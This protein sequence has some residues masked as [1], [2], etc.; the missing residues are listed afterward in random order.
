MPTPEQILSGLDDISNQWRT[1]AIVWHAY[2]GVLVLALIVRLGASKRVLGILLALP[3]LSV[4]AL[5][6]ASG[7]PFNGSFFACLG[8]G[9]IAIALAFPVDSTRVAPF[10]EVVSGSLMFLFGWV[11]PHFVDTS[12]MVLYL[13]AAPTGFLAF[14]GLMTVAAILVN[15][16]KPVRESVD[17]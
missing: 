10:W 16:K 3:L 13:Y 7:N 4:S 5:A 6:W 12:S 8:M 11:Y 14:G 1:L 15:R 2:F 9:L 17:T